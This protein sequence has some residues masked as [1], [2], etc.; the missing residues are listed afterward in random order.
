MKIDEVDIE[1]SLQSNHA[2]GPSVH[3]KMEDA[4]PPSPNGWCFPNEEATRPINIDFFPQNP[5]ILSS[6]VKMRPGR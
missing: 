1:P 4:V 6:F 5:Q 3:R 2:W